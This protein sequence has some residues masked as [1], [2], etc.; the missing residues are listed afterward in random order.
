MGETAFL[1]KL[2][3]AAGGR[4]GRP[5]AAEARA[6]QPLALRVAVARTGERSVYIGN[7]AQTLHP[8]AG[9]GLNL[10]LRDAWDL[11]QIMRDAQ[12]PGDGA[13][14]ARF[15]AARRLDAGAAI[16]VTD[17][18]ARIFLTSNPL[19]GA[20]RSAALAALDVFPAPRRFFARR[21]IFGPSAL[22]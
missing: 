19:A 20:A 5:V 8:V 14:L 2:A 13:T 18:L 6:V 4:P 3:I 7:A 15:A 16:R 17:L 10:G 9:Q 22:P 12:D 11:A 1:E 21:M